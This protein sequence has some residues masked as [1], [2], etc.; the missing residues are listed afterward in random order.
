MS[1]IQP[2]RA[3][4]K[5][6]LFWQQVEHKHGTVLAF[7]LSQYTCTNTEVLKKTFSKQPYW[8]ICYGTEQGIY[9]HHFQQKNVI[10]SLL[11]QKTIAEFCFFISFDNIETWQFIFPKKTTL[12]QYLKKQERRI[13]IIG[14]A[15]NSNESYSITKDDSSSTVNKTPLEHHLN[16][17]LNKTYNHFFTLDFQEQDIIQL[18]RMQIAHKECK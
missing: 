16:S 5:S 14:I 17:V 9:F 3:P 8:G 11:G 18:L 1:G 7:S 4:D 2:I 6:E 12:L 15:K 13:S 10:G